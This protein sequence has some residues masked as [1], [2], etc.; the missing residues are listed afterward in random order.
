MDPA[1]S[2]VVYFAS[3]QDGL[4]A[5]EDAG[6]T[7]AKIGAVPSGKPP[8]GVTTVVFDPRGGT[9]AASNKGGA[10]TKSIFVTVEEGGIFKTDDAGST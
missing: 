1:N 7:W 8:H 4:W 10:K 2:S 6:E 3:I 5:T 9:L